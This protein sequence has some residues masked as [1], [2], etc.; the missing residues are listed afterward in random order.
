MFGMGFNIATARLGLVTTVWT[1]RE[2]DLE[3]FGVEINFERLHSPEAFHVSDAHASQD[4]AAR[5]RN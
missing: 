2:G 3:W 5:A 4:G 1:T